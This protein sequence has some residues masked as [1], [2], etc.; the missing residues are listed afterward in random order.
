MLNPPGDDDALGN[1]PIVVRTTN[2]RAA[3]RGHRATAT[4]LTADI[5]AEMAKDGGGIKLSWGCSIENW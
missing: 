5:H 2:P 4:K 3:R 1:E